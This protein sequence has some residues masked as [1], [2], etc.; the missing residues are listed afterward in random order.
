M[1]VGESG[2]VGA[3]HL[4]FGGHYRPRLTLDYVRYVFRT[5]VNH[6]LLSFEN[7]CEIKG[8]KFDEADRSSVMKFAQYELLADDPE[9]E[10]ALEMALL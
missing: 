6:P 8:R 7:D 1:I 4:N 5:L 2:R 10:E 3:I 9:A